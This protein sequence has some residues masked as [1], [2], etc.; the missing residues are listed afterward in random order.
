[1]DD[2]ITRGWEELIGRDAGPLH[3]RLLFQPLVASLLAIRSGLRDARERRPVFF[4]T[5]VL[6]PTQRRELVRHGGQDVGKL[7]IT[8]VILDVIYQLIVLHWFYPV[9]TLIVATALAI[10]PYL[11]FRGLTNRIAARIRPLPETRSISKGEQSMTTSA[12]NPVPAGFD[13]L[14]IL[15]LR[16]P[17][18]T[19][20]GNRLLAELRAQGPVC[21][22][23]PLGLL[24]FLRWAECDA[25]L[26][27]FKN[28]SAAFARSQPVPGAEE[29]T[30]I[31]TLL[32]EDPPKHTRVRT[33]MQ[34]AFTPQ[35]VAAMEPHTRD[36]TRKLIDDI[37]ARGNECD[38]LH[39]FALP[40]PS[41]VMS[42]LLG[43]D[44]SM[45]ETFARW[46]SSMMGA[47][48]AHAIKDEAAR[49]KRY[50]EL[51]RDAKDMEA[52]L[53]ERIRERRKSPQQ[54]LI[55]YLIQA[56][57]GNDHLTE[58]EALTL[59]KLCIIAGNDLTTQAIALTLDCL[60]GH[61]DQ[62]RLLADDLSLA[63]NAF[64]ES[65]RFNGPVSMLQ[66]KALWDVEIAGVKVPAGCVVSP[67]VSSANHDETVFDKPEV[68]D[69]RR[70]IP[71]ILSMSS[72]NH[73]CIGQP[74][75][76]LEA[77]VAFEE[78]FARVLSFARKGPPE[79]CGQMGLRGFEK[80]PV[81]LQRRP[82]KVAKA[83]QDSV[84]KQ[85][86]T[87]EKIAGMSDPQLGLDKRQIMTVR[88][89]G[90]WD[91][92]TTTK[93]FVLTHPSGGLLPRFTPGS[94]IVIHMRDGAR[95]HRNSYSLING[96]Y[97]EG[98]AYFIAAQL[99]PNSKGGS[100]Y[101]HEQV[102]RGAELTISVPANYFPVAE[103]AIK[104]LL[105]A[106]GIG[107][108]PL[109]A[110][111]S[112]LKL[113]EQRVELH[114]AFRS[115]ETAAFVPFLSFQN[116][117]NVHLYDDSLGH[118][119]DIPALIRRQPEGTHVYSCGPAGFMDAVVN[120]AEVARLAARNDSRRALRRRAQQG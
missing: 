119:L 58:R 106:G 57:E 14:P 105:I 90:I 25:I 24:G 53:L 8:A 34:Q 9:Q 16:N 65:L 116:D 54:D 83:P 41:T 35:R 109:L 56:A 2:M 19:V 118:K 15:D 101:L 33:L 74:L 62:M 13:S 4:W 12:T 86:A 104:H 51:A 87:A 39:Q 49:Q 45:T 98:L 71:R 31:D 72:G 73:Q 111:R 30:K 81:V 76:R 6:D 3:A 7:F 93:L 50:G 60:L 92:S 66:R 113:L 5:V 107:I 55:S 112:H 78:W 52:F 99:A 59:M 43:V 22:V 70:K 28:F 84:V 40:L 68:F 69:I 75:A 96:G 38:F 80:L 37:L 46:A 120:A 23:E 88:V 21:R 117:P 95:V 10:M 94:H 1:M 48:T 102:K 85:M 100:K 44:A 26:R 103:H 63:A 27:D 20:E 115:A 91:V 82:A 32:R 114:Y 97:G 47:N 89:A 64:E 18:F 79:L 67:V 77:R 108:T 36:L 17:N 11:V 110:H 61:P 42:G 29:E